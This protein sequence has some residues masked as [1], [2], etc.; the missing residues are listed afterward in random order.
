MARTA[1][2]LLGMVIVG[3]LGYIAFAIATSPNISWHVV[4]K[5]LFSATVMGGL[6][7]TLELTALACI[8]GTIIGTVLGVMSVSKLAALRY[9]AAGYVWFFRA[10]PLLIQI[11]FWFNIA[12][13]VPRIDVFFVHANVNHLISPFR[14]AL[15]ALGLDTAAYVSEIVRSGVVSVDS[16][17]RD[18]AAS[19]G[20]RSR[21]TMYRVI[22]PQALR[23]MLPPYGSLVITVLKAT[24]LVSVIGTQDLLTRTNTIASDTFDTMELLFV[25]VFWYLVLVSVGT[26]FQRL[27]ERRLGRVTGGGKGQAGSGWRFLTGRR[28]HTMVG[29]GPEVT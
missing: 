22:L 20:L 8:L 5:Y 14:A 10:T 18:A 23:V 16:G 9:F 7:V 17:Q 4:G 26:L 3:I 21:Q 24:S 25:A 1:S 2:L 19:V 6:G 11:V 29:L 12:L 28:G 27:F 13:F 15:L